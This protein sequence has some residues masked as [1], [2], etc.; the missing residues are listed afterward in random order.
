MPACP[1]VTRALNN[2]IASINEDIAFTGEYDK[3][4]NSR[5]LAV[6]KLQSMKGMDKNGIINSVKNT[7]DKGN[8]YRS[9]KSRIGETV[10]IQ[11]GYAPSSRDWSNST[12][13][14]LSDVSITKGVAKVEIVLADGK[15]ETFTFD[16]NSP[17]EWSIKSNNVGVQARIRGLVPAVREWVYASGAD[18]TFEGYSVEQKKEI[19]NKILGSIE[20]GNVPSDKDLADMLKYTQDSSYGHGNIEDMKSM[21]EKLHVLGGRKADQEYV[22]HI[23]GLFDRMRPKFFNDMKLYIGENKDTSQGWVS[24]D[25]NAIIVDVSKSKDWY[26]SDAEVYAHE[27]VHTMTYW[28]LRNSGAEASK[29]KRQLLFAMRNAAAHTK[30]EDLL[31]VPKEVATNADWEAANKMY[32]YIFKSSN[33]IDEF[34]A[35]A[36]TNPRLM[37]HLAKINVKEVEENKTVLQK[38]VDAFSTLL[39]VALGRFDFADRNKT[40]SDQVHSLA[41]KLGEINNKAYESSLSLNPISWMLNSVDGALDVLDNTL[42]DAMHNFAEK[43]FPVSDKLEKLP[44]NATLLQKS[45]YTFKFFVKA[46]RHEVYRDALGLYLS[47]LWL[48]P[49]GS[50]RQWFAELVEEDKD[51]KAVNWLALANHHLDAIRNATASQTKK[52]ILDSFKVPLSEAQEEALTSVLLDTDMGHLTYTKNGRQGWDNQKLRGLLEDSNKLDRAVRDAKGKLRAYLVDDKERANTVNDLA[53]SLG[54]FMATGKAHKMT[55]YSSRNIVRGV[56]QGHRYKQDNVLEAHVKELATLVALQH[57]DDKAKKIV[58]ELL[59]NE[60][61]GTRKVMDLYE[62]FKHESKAELFKDDIAHYMD[63]Y[64]K[65]LLDDTI[66]HVVEPMSKKAELESDGFK[67]VGA[68]GS[69]ID[70]DTSKHMGLFITE[71]YWKANRARGAVN[72]GDDKAK[73]A[74]L[75]SI[76]FRAN[77]DMGNLIFER[78]MSKANREAW[79]I[80]LDMRKGT[81]DISKADYGMGAV[82]NANGIVVDYRI[83]MAKEQKKKLLKQNTKISDVL[84]RSIASVQDKAQRDVHDTN[85]LN[86]LKEQMKDWELGGKGELGGTTGLKE[87]YLIGPDVLDKK[88]KE[89]Y[90]MLPHSY[91]EYITS[92]EDKVLAVKKDLLHLLFGYEH[93]QISKAYGVNKLPRY[94]RRILNLAER[95][96]M[97]LVSIAKGNII[98]KI[99]AII[100]TNIVSNVIQLWTMGVPLK[101]IVSM[102]IDSF[103]NVKNYIND[104]RDKLELETKVK[105]LKAKLHRVEDKAKT[106]AE[107]RALQAEIAVIQKKMD[108]NSVKELVDI[109][110]M[111]SLVEDVNTAD[112][113][114]PNMI[115]QFFNN[116][117]D[118]V[119]GWV[120]KGTDILYL[121]KPT[122]WYKSFQ[123]AVQMSDLVARDVLNKR[124]KWYE[125]K[126]VE[127][128]KP[129]PQETIDKM[130]ELG[131][132]VISGQPMVGAT[133]DMFLAIS[134][135]YRHYLL[136]KRFVNYVQ[137]NGRTE[138]YLNKIGLVMFTKYVKRIQR[139]VIEIGG[140][141]PGRA[142][143]ATTLSATAGIDSIQS[144]FMF[145]KGWGADGDFEITNIVPVYNPVEVG[146]RAVNPPLIDLGGQ[147][148]YGR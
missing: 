93:M 4:G 85:V 55:V 72:M 86:E 141:H 144:G 95:F 67:F 20:E 92:R 17:S 7:N 89:L 117:L 133:K 129:V 136:L 146:V 56:M 19:I 28:G 69:H 98:L 107:I 65:E 94:I 64:S 88:M 115:T 131:Y 43:Y 116:K 9:I 45:A 74:S 25:K 58:G 84:S 138:E 3:E 60:Y 75:K 36:L 125:Q 96:W 103:R 122:L 1:S 53:V 105:A 30:P 123:E 127:G 31:R 100:Y 148:F 124:M 76:S 99:P 113:N 57:T 106:E 139:Q 37:K 68:V 52:D 87:Y 62:S 90:Y 8:A 73:G 71:S 130:A 18:K 54:Y 12:N 33:S 147:L 143:I 66:M 38:I 27:V 81:F 42:K 82:V 142:S 61:E 11:Y 50:F 118:K 135:E 59:K 16:S 101:D 51:K 26:Q 119:P 49:E 10:K 97:D 108:E 44:E 46:A 137:L 29:L 83:M 23:K 109:N 140:D 5:P 2:K 91:R 80:L 132:T 24:I 70:G 134:K 114:D 47:Q 104:G 78:D 32:A 13:A 77:A 110:L 111:Q 22:D 21:L 39:D 112:L 6:Q 63:G 145:V 48:R 40:V 15:V 34:V 126:Q 79:D 120:K 14:V 128:E 121:T 41:F 102:H 35:H